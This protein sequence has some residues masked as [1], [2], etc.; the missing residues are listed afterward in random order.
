MLTP[1]PCLLS[2]T[3]D[4]PAQ[5]ALGFS[6]GHAGVWF[7]SVLWKAHSAAGAGAAV[8]TEGHGEGGLCRLGSWHC[9][10]PSIVRV[11]AT[12][13]GLAPV[14]G[15]SDAGNPPLCLN[16]SSYLQLVLSSASP[17]VLLM[18]RPEWVSPALHAAV[19]ASLLLSWMKLETRHS[20]PC[21]YT[22]PF[23]IH[24]LDSS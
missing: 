9:S 8:P 14:S 4:F 12:G 10:W 24:S 15:V 7:W 2:S 19:P 3:P 16:P 11:L 6:Q 22:G 1:E 5:T 20:S 21:L 17:Q 23:P 13:P 18:L